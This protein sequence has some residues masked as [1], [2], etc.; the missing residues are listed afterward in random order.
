MERV[1]SSVTGVTH[2]YIF[3]LRYD[4]GE[5][6]WD[7]SGRVARNLAAEKGW[8]LQSI[9][10]NGSHIW[11]E[12]QNLVFTYSS[13]KLDLVQGQTQQVPNLLS[14]GNSRRSP[15]CSLAL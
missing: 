12:D 2:R 8:A 9:D 13:T 5:L 11:N 14:S 15:R 10:P 3:E 4:S 6:Y 7:R 1:V